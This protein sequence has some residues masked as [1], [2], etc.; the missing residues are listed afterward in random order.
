MTTWFIMLP[1]YPTR[2]PGCRFADGRSASA[3]PTP[4]AHLGHVVAVHH[5]VP[6]VLLE[7]PAAEARGRLRGR[8][9]AQP[10]HAFEHVER[11]VEAGDVVQHRHVERR[12]RRA[13][14]L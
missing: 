4:V 14:L 5:D 9:P 1:I 12:R 10:R 7:L 13:L 3:R 11:E 8:V 2:L 6:P